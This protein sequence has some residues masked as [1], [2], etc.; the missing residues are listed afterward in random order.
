MECH[1]CGRGI[2]WGEPYVSVDYHIERTVPP[3]SIEVERAD[4]LFT[5]FADCAPSRDDLVA[6]L[7]AAGYGRGTD[8]AP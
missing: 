8:A 5:G 6:A 7:M 3:N 4:S 2:P 1:R